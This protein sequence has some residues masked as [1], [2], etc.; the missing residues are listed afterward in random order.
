MKLPFRQGLVRY[1]K[2]GNNPAFLSPSNGGQSIS[3]IATSVDPTVITLAHRGSDY[4]FEEK[5]NVSAAW[6]GPFS[7]G[8][9]DYW[10]YWDIDLLTGVRTF[11]H[12]TIQP[13][14]SATAPS[15]ANGKHWF[16]TTEQIMKVGTGTTWNEVVRVF[17]AKYDNGSII[18]YNTSGTQVGLNIS[19]FSGFII[20]DEDDNPI[21]KF[22]RGRK[23]EFITTESPLTSHY[24]TGAMS[25]TVDGALQLVESVD[26]IPVWSVVSNKGPNQ[27]GLGSFL[28]PEYPL[29]GIAPE[30]FNPAEV[31]TFINR[32]YVSNINWAWTQP[33]GT[34]L[35]S[36]I[37]GEVTT[38]VPQQGFIQQI[39]QI[40]SYNTIF[41][42]IGPQILLGA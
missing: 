37:T 31:G 35:F 39:G 15:Q 17:A 13:V 25:F 3:L 7:P 16:D 40:V 27:I 38:S 32:G 23:S 19:V 41:V 10:L 8:T 1:K 18:V 36:G 14:V 9:I 22:A 28:T 5:A 34:P 24:S 29:I 12:T 4:L 6:A 30:D 33:A 11:G 2:S 26:A 42:D 21:R 20:F